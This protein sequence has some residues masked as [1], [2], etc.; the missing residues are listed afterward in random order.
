MKRE[1]RHQA[2]EQG[3]AGQTNIDGLTTPPPIER[4]PRVAVLILTGV[5]AIFIALLFGSQILALRGYEDRAFAL[6][7]KIN[8]IKEVNQELER[9][10]D[11]AAS[12]A[13]VEDTLLSLNF[14]KNTDIGYVG[15]P[16]PAISAGRQPFIPEHRRS[17]LPNWQQWW[18]W[19][20]GDRTGLPR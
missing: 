17:P 19:F 5:T 18:N 16:E 4:V 1:R 8:Q 6:E 12:D 10:K 9:Q 20:F 2:E 14:Q 15:I 3:P 11:Y 7:Q 13:G